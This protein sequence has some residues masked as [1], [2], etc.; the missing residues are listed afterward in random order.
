MLQ[1]STKSNDSLSFPSLPAMIASLSMFVDQC[2]PCVTTS[3]YEPL[4]YMVPL[5][6]V[7]GVSL[8]NLTVGVQ[9][10]SRFCQR[11][12]SKFDS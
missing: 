3:D 8:F 1:M 2:R 7:K 5:S 12:T 10:R 11:L 4:V 6:E 9:L